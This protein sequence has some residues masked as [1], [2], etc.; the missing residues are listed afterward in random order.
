MIAM[1]ATVSVWQF[2][3]L[4][5]MLGLTK[6]AAMDVVEMNRLLGQAVRKALIDAD[7]PVKAAVA[8]MQVDHSQFNKALNGEAYRHLSLN[9]LIKLG[10][11]FMAHLTR[12]LMWLTAEH[13]VAELRQTATEMVD[14]V[15][16]RK[17]A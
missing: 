8:T 17:Q 2:V 11:V 1:H 16:V 13:R 9:H 10:P 12:H 15:R 5:V 7:I 3:G 6:C 14:A 4:G